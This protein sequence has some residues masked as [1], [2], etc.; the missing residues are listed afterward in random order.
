MPAK[1][2]G[3]PQRP[4]GVRCSTLSCRPWICSRA[5]AGQRRVDPARQDGIDLD[6]VLGPRGRHRLG[7]LHHAALARGIGGGEGRAE[8]RH[9]RADI[10]DLA[11]AAL[12]HLGVGGMAAQEGAGEVAVHHR[13]PFGERVL[14]G[15]L[16][17]A[18]AGIV[19]QDV[20]A[21]MRLHGVGDQ[22]A[23]GVFLQDIDRDGAGLGAGLLDLLDRRGVLGG[24]TARHDDGGAGARHA[25]RHAEPNAA[26]AAGDHGDAAGKIEKLHVQVPPSGRSV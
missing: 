26:V 6:V 15:L 22:G 7:H 21:A 10:D 3:S 2:D 8:D 1:S 12:L 25:E 4:A 18:H 9:H 24:V 17:D 16:A 19:D 20:E 11:H 14:L 23:A 5:P 13:V